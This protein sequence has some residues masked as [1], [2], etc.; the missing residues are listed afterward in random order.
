M[1]PRSLQ[2]ICGSVLSTSERTA[3]SYSICASQMSKFGNFSLESNGGKEEQFQ[4]AVSR[5]KALEA[6]QSTLRMVS[7]GDVKTVLRGI[8]NSM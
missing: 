5:M 3:R 8:K 6:T 2:N 7:V 4:G 1:P